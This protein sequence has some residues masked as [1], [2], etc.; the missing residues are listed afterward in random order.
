MP[1]VMGVLHGQYATPYV[2]IWLMVAVSA[3]IG[4]IGLI[5]VAALTGTTLASNIGT[6]ILYAI[7]CG[8]TLVAFAGRSEFHSIKHAIIPGL[9]IIGNLG[10]L[11]AI[12]WVGLTAGGVS[13]QATL[14]ALGITVVW[15]VISAVYLVWNSRQQE[16][17]ILSAQTTPSVS[18]D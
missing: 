10:M 15:G 5:N 18:G 13:T 11:V 1:D 7:I 17:P 4:S 9:G 3:V 6:F 16:K 2:G 8:V 12:L 14:L